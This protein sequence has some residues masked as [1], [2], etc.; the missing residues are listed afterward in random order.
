MEN[1]CQPK[2]AHFLSSP[3]LTTRS[4]SILQ[5]SHRTGPNTALLF[6]KKVIY[7]T[8]TTAA[9]CFPYF[10][11]QNSNRHQMGN[12]SRQ[13][14]EIHPGSRSTPM[15]GGGGI[16][17]AESR[18][19]ICLDHRSAKCPPASRSLVD[20]K[21]IFHVRRKKNPRQRHGHLCLRCH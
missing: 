12:I 21:K 11:Q 8:L 7:T 3:I 14:E 9:A 13:T 17:D 2:H 10:Q 4:N 15:G 5:L 1:D 6:C 18:D 16:T 20:R 19:V